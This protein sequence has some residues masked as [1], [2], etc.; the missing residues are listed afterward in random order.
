[1]FLKMEPGC[2]LLAVIGPMVMAAVIFTCLTYRT[3]DGASLLISEKL[4]IRISG[5]RNLLFHQIK[6]T[7]IL[8]A[9]GLADMGEVIFTYHICYLTEHGVNPK[10][11][12]LRSIPAL[13]KLNRL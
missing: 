13:M 8:P 10:I 5:N 6:G 7:F 4:L 1:M 3:M 11:W 12:V 2:S 9:G